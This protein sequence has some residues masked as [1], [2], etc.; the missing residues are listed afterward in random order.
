MSRFNF[1]KNKVEHYLFEVFFW[2]YCG[3]CLIL[4]GR[5][6]HSPLLV[7][8]FFPSF[9]IFLLLSKKKVLS[10]LSFPS[11]LCMWKVLS[12]P[13]SQSYVC[14]WNVLSTRPFQSYVCVVNYFFP[15]NWLT[16][17]YLHALFNVQIREYHRK[18][19]AARVVDAN[20]DYEALLKEEPVIEF[21]GEVFSRAISFYLS[22][23]LLLCRPLMQFCICF[24]TLVG[25]EIW[26]LLII[27]F[28]F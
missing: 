26:V 10:T 14:M 11:Y 17:S 4:L 3:G 28:C 8:F 13:P 1:Y 16:S 27:W 20:E 15:W 7:L 22:F 12:T 6:S 9:I 2:A 23:S 24:R 25:Q 5:M 18:H 19:P 21:S